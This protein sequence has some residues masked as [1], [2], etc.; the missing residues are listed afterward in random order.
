[1][2]TRAYKSNKKSFVLEIEDGNVGC[3]IS[4]LKQWCAD[5]SVSYNKLYSTLNTQK[6]YEGFR[7]Q[8]NYVFVPNKS[9]TPKNDA[10]IV[11]E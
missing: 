6:F 2:E 9:K 11:I 3:L 5:K 7:L 8:R 4:N 1:M 10:T